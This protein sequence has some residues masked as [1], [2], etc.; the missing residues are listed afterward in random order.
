MAGPVPGLQ[1]GAKKGPDAARRGMPRIGQMEGLH[2]VRLRSRRNINS[3]PPATKP[4]TRRGMRRISSARVAAFS[5]TIMT[6]R[7]ITYQWNRVEI[8]VNETE[9]MIL[10]L[11]CGEC[12]HQCTMNSKERELS[13]STI[14]AAS[15][16]CQ[17]GCTRLKFYVRAP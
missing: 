8:D 17:A 11:R 12:R 7:R 14:M 13:G 5:P 10:V 4:Q 2:T 6:P 1:K 16:A 9:A 15:A 3:G